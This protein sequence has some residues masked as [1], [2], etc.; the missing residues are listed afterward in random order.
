MYELKNGLLHKDGKPIIALGVSYYPSFHEAKYPVPPDGDRISE[1][2]KDYARIRDAGF[3]MVRL[4]A[5]GKVELENNEIKVDTPFIDE[6]VRQAPQY[7]LCTTIRLQGY[8]MNLRGYTDYAMRN[9]KDE[10]M[11]FSWSAFLRSS[12]FHTGIC[13]DNQDATS[14]LAKH[15]DGMPGVLS[16]QIY[17]EPHYPYNGIFDYH[18]MTLA[19]YRRW[20]EANNLDPNVEAPRHRPT[21]G[22]SPEPWI[23]WRLFSMKALTHFLNTSAEAAKKVAPSKETYTCMTSSPAVTPGIMDMGINYFDNAESSMDEVGIT[24]YIHVEGMDAYSACLQFAMAESAAALN[25]KHAWTVEIDARTHMPARKLHQETYALLAAGHKGINYY[26]WRG[27]YPAEGSPNPDNCGFILSDGSKAKHYDR[28]MDMIRFVNRYSTQFAIANKVREGIAILSSETAAALSDAYMS[29]L[30]I[31]PY[32]TQTIETYQQLRR[33]GIC[34]DFVR[35]KDLETN[36][37]GIHLL[38]LPFDKAWL[39]K[40]ERCQID[41]Y[42]ASGGRAFYYNQKGTF[43]ASVPGGWWDYTSERLDDTRMEFRGLLCMEDILE[44]LGIKAVVRP[45]N[46]H[47]LAGVLMGKNSW[48]IPVINIDPARK[49]VMGAKIYTQIT[50]KKAVWCTPEGEITLKVADSFVELPRVRE[51]GVLMLR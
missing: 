41:A 31:N 26:E 47:L 45:D 3:Q 42:I 39:S 17:N 36:L 12:F 9:H 33:T 23:Q 21:E 46:R 8:V 35:A 18:P 34:P 6:C 44:Q 10:T 22:E 48:L 20:R 32:I 28:S 4:A 38:L 27:D 30:K 50:Y 43:D 25:G 2:K 16:Y 24:C 15:Y 14:A 1:M 13:K 19:A 37:F 49:E 40:D 11:E 29:G 7:D 51:G 5:L